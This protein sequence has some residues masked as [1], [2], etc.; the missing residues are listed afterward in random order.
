MAASVAGIQ[1]G[2]AVY[3]V[4]NN[5]L[6]FSGVFASATSGLVELTIANFINPPTIQPSTYLL[7][8][9]DSSGYLIISGSFILTASLKTLQSNVVAPSSYTVLDNRVTYTATFT[10]NFPFTSVSITLP[11]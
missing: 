2:A 9:Q 8:I 3:Q 5:Q 4:S 6:V 11:S 7:N 1:V 10:S